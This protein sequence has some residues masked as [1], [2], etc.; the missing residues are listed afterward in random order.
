MSRPSLH[1]QGIPFAFRHA[2]QRMVTPDE[3]E[4]G[5]RC[6][7]VCKYCGAS[8]IARKGP[9][10]VWHFAHCSG[11][12]CSGGVET[13]VH[14]MAKQ[15]IVDRKALW[16]PVRTQQRRVNGLNGVWTETLTVDVQS[17]GVVSLA[18]CVQ[19][20]TVA[21]TGQASGVRRP[22][23]LASL[24]G[25]P[26]AI[27]I[28]NTHAVDDEKLDW[29]RACELSAVEI[30]VS[31][32]SATDSGAIKEEL[33]RRLFSPSAS[34]KWLLH[35]GDAE[36]LLRLDDDERTLRAAKA[37]DEA[38]LLAER[39]RQQAEY[40]KRRQFS[41]DVREL[42]RTEL[43]LGPTATLRVVRGKIRCTV[44]WH[45]YAPK[46]ATKV[47]RD[48][49]RRFSGS[50]RHEARRWEYYRR[51]GTED[52]YMQIVNWAKE[53]LLEPA[54][55]VPLTMAPTTLTHV[56]VRSAVAFPDQSE[57]E[58]FDER[59]AIMEFD[60]NLSR[61]TAEERA[62][63]EIARGDSRHSKCRPSAT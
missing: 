60:G 30:R 27:E 62:R 59:A 18:H 20:Q 17:A 48:L 41:D 22:D 54:P 56:P 14:W 33:V 25:H 42:E 38:S 46:H 6:G 28:C 29:L 26:V 32:L 15:L 1:N 52:L 44:R 53:H 55:H 10:R 63:E 35:F 47:V 3:V 43:P 19:E 4:K 37:D 49:A 51:E 39:S 9:E 61:V 11:G 5:L 31:D 40:T 45:G 12:C 23:I 24:N 16:V 36:A 13:A 21:S 50:F 2:D 57:Q 34:S 58:Q 8:L 7:C